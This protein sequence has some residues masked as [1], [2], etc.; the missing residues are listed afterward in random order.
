MNEIRDTATDLSD[1][2]K[3]MAEEMEDRV[4]YAENDHQR[5]GIIQQYLLKLLKVKGDKQMTYC[6]EQVS[7]ANGQLSV[8][9]LSARTNISQRQLARKF[10]DWIGVSPK[11]YAQMN[12]FLY[13]LQL[14]KKESSENL[15]EIAY[16]SGYYDQA[17]FIREYKAYAG[18]TPGELLSSEKRILY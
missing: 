13:S 17:H 2:W 18:L 8:N 3:S 14:M 1:L 11:E 7:A 12:R 6:I 15:T 16:R 10:N 9:E 4:C 5:A